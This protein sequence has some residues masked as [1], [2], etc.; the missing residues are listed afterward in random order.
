MVRELASIA[1][2]CAKTSAGASPAH[3]RMLATTKV[4]VRLPPLKAFL[5]ILLVLKK[6]FPQ[7]KRDQSK[8]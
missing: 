6:K 7:Q 3:A 4:F 1:S 5:F 2:D 8:M